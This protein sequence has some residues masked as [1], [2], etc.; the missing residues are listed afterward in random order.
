MPQPTSE[1]GKKPTQHIS[2][3]N[4]VK[5]RPKYPGKEMKTTVLIF[6]I[7]KDPS[8]IRNGESCPKKQAWK[9]IQRGKRKKR[10]GTSTKSTKRTAQNLKMHQFYKEMVDRLVLGPTG[11]QWKARM[12]E[13]G[14][15]YKPKRIDCHSDSLHSFWPLLFILSGQGFI[16][17]F[18]F[19]F[20]VSC[21]DTHCLFLRCKCL[22]TNLSLVKAWIHG[23]VELTK[24]VDRARFILLKSFCHA[25]RELNINATLEREWFATEN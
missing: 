16:V 21:N 12:V 10:K 13:I 7:W 1:S 25:G 6:L 4:W 8:Q 20:C 9:F 24:D 2:K 14:S 3:V 11:I 15:D 18:L 5:K 17:S 22:L 19:Y 23:S